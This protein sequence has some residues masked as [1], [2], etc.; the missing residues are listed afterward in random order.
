ML[1]E[2]YNLG[3][4]TGF[5][6]DF[7]IDTE[8]PL[9]LTPQKITGWTAVV[10]PKGIS[11]LSGTITVDKKGAAFVSLERVYKNA[12]QNPTDEVF[13]TI[14]I[15]INGASSFTRTLPI[16]PAGGPND[17]EIAPFTSNSVKVFSKSDTI[18]IYASASDAGVTP[19]DTSIIT[20]RLVIKS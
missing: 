15:R 20:A 11:E 9:T 4:S 10:E 18:E 12:D 6:C 16:S 7:I 13:L 14:D 3:G 5:Y 2:D 19:Q 1:S 17:P 8:I